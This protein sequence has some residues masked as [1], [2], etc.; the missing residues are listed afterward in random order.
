L[1]EERKRKIDSACFFAQLAVQRIELYSTVPLFPPLILRRQSSHQR[2][3]DLKHIVGGDSN[4]WR[5]RF[6]HFDRR[7][8]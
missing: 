5:A 2:E 3:K 1:K 8:K 4:A 7:A 6:G